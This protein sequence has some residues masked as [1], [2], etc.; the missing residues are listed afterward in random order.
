[1]VNKL[2]KYYIYRKLILLFLLCSIISVIVI[3]GFL[4]RVFQRTT[5]EKIYNLTISDLY[6]SSYP[7]DQIY[8]SISP[9]ISYILASGYFTPLLEADE[10]DR[11]KEYYAKQKLDQLQI[12]NS[13]FLNIGLANL[14]TD[15]YVGTNGVYFGIDKELTS[16]SDKESNKGLYC[17]TRK[18]QDKSGGE[19]QP[20]A[21]VLTFIYYPRGMYSKGCIV[22]D[23]EISGMQKLFL[24]DGIEQMDSDKEMENGKEITEKRFVLDR[25]GRMLISEDRESAEVCQKILRDKKIYESRQKEG[26]FD[27]KLDGRKRVT[28]YVKSETSGNIYVSIYPKSTHILREWRKEIIT[29]ALILLIL[30]AAIVMIM[31]RHIYHPIHKL[32]AKTGGKEGEINEIEAL[33]KIFEEYESQSID[34]K[35]DRSRFENILKINWLRS[36]LTG[37]AKHVDDDKLKLPDYCDYSFSSAYLSV[38]VFSLDYYKKYLQAFESKDRDLVE[39][40]IS[41]ILNELLGKYCVNELIQTDENIR[42]VVIRASSQELPG[43]VI[44]GI[45]ELQGYFLKYLNLS[46]SASFGNFVSDW[47]QLQVS[48]SSAAKGL[49]KRL[50]LGTSEIIDGEYDYGKSKDIAYPYKAVKSLREVILLENMEK[51]VKAADNFIVRVSNAEAENI[52]AYIDK[53]LCDVIGVLYEEDDGREKLLGEVRAE[54]KNAVTLCDVTVILHELCGRLISLKAA[55]S[56]ETELQQNVITKAMLY[57]DGHYAEDNLSVEAVA[58]MMNLSP[59]YFGKLFFN[60]THLYCND[61]IGDI[62]MKKAAWLLENTSETVNIISIKIG[63]VNTNY[64]YVLFKKKYG[65][66]PA[67][68]RKKVTKK[69][70]DE[71]V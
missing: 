37:E 13:L 55:R 30:Y 50:Y 16:V 3:S 52:I 22:I 64:F 49:H 66:T 7:I 39:F 33:K 67:Q 20:E 54:V 32:I 17:I 71:E 5:D 59:S 24:Q 70:E 15:R 26:C 12:S 8:S 38:I 21:D 10:V 40:I 41:N 42:V 34:W 62:R 36:V 56:Q 48:Y 57:I 63:I 47:E 4:Y 46:V 60:S 68:Y 53:C 29:A 18:L 23:A 65:V 11:L 51:A 35:S 14:M 61:Y 27:I 44:L 69:G 28:A 6:K 43:E 9:L 1:M 2:R 19:N 45:K 58:E 25:E 31:L